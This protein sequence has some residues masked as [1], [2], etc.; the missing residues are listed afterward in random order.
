MKAPW[1]FILP[2][3]VPLFAAMALLCACRLEPNHPDNGQNVVEAPAPDSP[4]LPRQPPLDR[5]GLFAAV[6]R[7]ASAE[8]SGADDGSAQRMLDGRQFELR[9]RFGCGGPSAQLR[10]DWLGWSFD[11]ERRTLRVRAKPTLGADDALVKALGGDE[12][13]AVEGFWIPR[14]WLLQP[15]CP[16]A[17]AVRPARAQSG[18]EGEPATSNDTAGTTKI[19]SDPLP[20]SPRIGVAQF[21]TATDP[22]TG[23][24]EMRAY[25]AV[26]MLDPGQPASSQGFNLVLTGRLRSLPG[27]GVIVCAGQGSDSPPD[28]IV[29]AVFDRVWIEEPAN[30]D[31]I[32]EWGGG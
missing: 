2:A 30:R 9:L 25:E 26:K 16:V 31:V 22:R 20:T 13:E 6:A 11:S 3:K 27:K 12:F 8:A 19:A 24:R 5:A 29:S 28:C 23:R 21:F 4:V 32:A 18:G 15:A 1:S 14:P 10:D 7:A 17:A